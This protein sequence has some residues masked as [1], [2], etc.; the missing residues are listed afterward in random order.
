VIR[1]TLQRH[2]GKIS[3]AAAELGISRHTLYELME[4]PGINREPKLPD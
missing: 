1:Q 3:S 2:S 4:K